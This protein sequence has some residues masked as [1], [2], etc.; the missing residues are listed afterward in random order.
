M[1]PGK[2]DVP[3]FS[4]DQHVFPSSEVLYLESTTSGAQIRYTTDGSEPTAQSK[5]YVRPIILNEGS[6]ALYKAKA[7]K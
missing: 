7:F 4:L 2:V 1:Q 3:T 5:L 6:L